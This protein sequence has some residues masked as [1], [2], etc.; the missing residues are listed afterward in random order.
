[1]SLAGSVWI[2][3][4]ISG[5]GAAD[6]VKIYDGGNTKFYRGEIG[7][8]LLLNPMASRTLNALTSMDADN[9][10][11]STWATSLFQDHNTDFIWG[12]FSQ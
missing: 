8:R 10:T 11:V 7:N 6:S 3:Y 9:S 2:P 4:N 12:T 1:M 5:S